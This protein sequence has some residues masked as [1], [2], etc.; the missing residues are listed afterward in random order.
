MRR[1]YSLDTITKGDDIAYNNSYTSI[2]DSLCN[3]KNIDTR[4]D[5]KL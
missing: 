3:H 4:H 5:S 1:R 2:E